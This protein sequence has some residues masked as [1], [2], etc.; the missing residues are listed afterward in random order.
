MIESQKGRLDKGNKVGATL[1]D[2]SKAFDVLDHDQLMAK[3]Y[4]HSFH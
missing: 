1:T 4:S 3:L 2:L